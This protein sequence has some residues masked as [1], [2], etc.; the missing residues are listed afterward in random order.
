MVCD[1]VKLVP[2]SCSYPF[3]YLGPELECSPPCELW[4]QEPDHYQT[5]ALSGLRSILLLNSMFPGS[6]LQ[7]TATNASF[8]SA[9]L[10]KSL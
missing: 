6:R 5:A 9:V 8:Q 3:V 7:S 1:W 10:H 4:Y 2:S